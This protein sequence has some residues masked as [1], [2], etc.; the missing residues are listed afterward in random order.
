AND[1]VFDEGNITGTL[2][3]T[4]K[5]SSVAIVLLIST[6]FALGLITHSFATADTLSTEW[7]GGICSGGTAAAEELCEV[8]V[9]SPFVDVTH[10]DVPACS[11]AEPCVARPLALQVVPGHP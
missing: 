4:S 6:C 9:I 8:T 11:S 10:G 7:R 5:G 1:C 2:H 3:E